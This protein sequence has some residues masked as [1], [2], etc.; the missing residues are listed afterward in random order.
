MP[1]SLSI[2]LDVPRPHRSAKKQLG[3]RL[4][5]V[6]H[7]Q[8][9][10]K[11]LPVLRPPPYY[12]P[13][14]SPAQPPASPTSTSPNSSIPSPTLLLHYS[15]TSSFTLCFLRIPSF[16]PA[17]GRSTSRGRLPT[18]RLHGDDFPAAD[19][20]AMF[21]LISAS[22]SRDAG[23]NGVSVQPFLCGAASVGVSGPRSRRQRQTE[24]DRSG[25]KSL[26]P[27]SFLPCP[28]PPT[29]VPPCRAHLR[30]P[31]SL[32]AVPTSAHLRPSLPC[33][34]PPTFVPPCRAHL[35]PLRSP[36]HAHFTHLRPLRSP[37][38]AHH[39]PSLP[40]PPPLT[41]AILPYPPSVLLLQALLSSLF[42]W[43]CSPKFERAALFTKDARGEPVFQRFDALR[44]RLSAKGPNTRRGDSTRAE[45]A[46]SLGDNS[47]PRNYQAPP[48]PPTPSTEV[49]PRRLAP[50]RSPK[51]LQK[52][53]RTPPY[54]GAPY[55]PGRFGLGLLTLE[56]RRRGYANQ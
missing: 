39:R 11:G 25:E 53:R 17:G 32:P 47:G 40:C 9:S 44:P 12:T 38:R 52:G 15:L 20:E 41:T 10:L 54:M 13:L 16:P 14:P 33:P 50:L 1:T 24:R 43:F 4:I 26:R 19:K 6:I 29:F 49:L 22:F 8:L 35:R 48:P 18:P 31:S 55:I 45:R 3:R 42:P 27:P 21:Y 30:P 46:R 7:T 36:C 23:V 5:G 2:D 51:A 56:Y 37:C 28:P 34:P